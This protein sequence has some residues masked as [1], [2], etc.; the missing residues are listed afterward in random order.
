[1]RRGAMLCR[2]AYL[3]ALGW[4]GDRIVAYLRDA[5]R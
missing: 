3:W 1:M 5:P 4:D 2:I